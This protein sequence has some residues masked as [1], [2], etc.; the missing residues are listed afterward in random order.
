MR[1][2]FLPN[3]NLIFTV[4]LPSANV[5]LKGA[6]MQLIRRKIWNENL[7]SEVV[8]WCVLGVGAA[9]LAVALFTTLI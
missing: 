5:N 2:T 4:K 6:N 8:D 7:G 9:S 1:N 3:F